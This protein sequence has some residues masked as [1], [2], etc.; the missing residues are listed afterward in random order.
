MY[1]TIV[2][3]FIFLKNNL[4]YIEKNYEHMGKILPITLFVISLTLWNF[5]Y[6]VQSVLEE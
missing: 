1:G 5:T 4:I 6:S 3:D 2:E